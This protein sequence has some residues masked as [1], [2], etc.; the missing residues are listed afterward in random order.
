MKQF[1]NVGNVSGGGV[2]LRL[3]A[4]GD[5]LTIDRDTTMEYFID[6]A[7][8][9]DAILG[10][11][12][13][14]GD[15]SVAFK[16]KD[17]VDEL[18]YCFFG[19]VATV[20]NGDGTFTHTFTAK[21]EDIPEFEIIK[22]VG[23]VQEKY[24]G[25]K[26][27]KI[28]WKTPANGDVDM[29]VEVLGKTGEV[30]TGI[31]PATRDGSKTFRVINGTLTWGG[32]ILAVGSV[33]IT[34]ERDAE[35]DGFTLSG[36]NGRTLIPEGNFSAKLKADVLADDVTMIT[37]FLAGTSKP[38]VITLSN[39]DGATIEIHVPNAIIVK[40]GKETQVDKQLLIEDVEF[41]GL[42]DGTNGSAY[43]VLTNDVGSYPRT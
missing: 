7:H 12:D 18:I 29:S 22:Q 31:L 10:K 9:Q 30:V 6:T 40:R 21:D 34:L 39:G 14:N 3:P 20:D 32:A 23:G 37:D 36:D 11:L 27:V 28:T 5:G 38:L 16:P 33:E 26:A 1:I 19:T 35:K 25:V 43:V 13:V 42:D 15:I 8:A 17:G 4:K 2:Y 41:E 24:T